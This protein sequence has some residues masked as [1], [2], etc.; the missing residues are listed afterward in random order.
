MKPSNHVD[1]VRQVL[2]EMTKEHPAKGA[3]LSYDRLINALDEFE[4]DMN[5]EEFVTEGSVTKNKH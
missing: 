5:R 1:K 4:H 3:W 2:S